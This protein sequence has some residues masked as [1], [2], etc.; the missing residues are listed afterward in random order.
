[1]TKPKDWWVLL[2]AFFFVGLLL[3]GQ[4]LGFDFVRW[5]D[6]LLIY[7]NPAI[8]GITLQNLKTI[9]TTYDPELYIPLTL[10]SYQVDYMLAGTNASMYHATNI[11]LHILNA[12]A[13]VAT[14]CL[15]TKRNGIAILVGIL[16]LVHPIHTEAVVWA[17]AR[18]DLLSTFFFLVSC[19]SFLQYNETGN[20]KWY[21]GSLGI[22]FLG[23]LCK[24]TVLTLPVV[25][26]LMVWKTRGIISLS[27]L[28][29]LIPYCIGSVVFAV[30]A[31]YGK[32][33]VLDLAT[34]IETIAMSGKGTAFYLSKLLAPVRLSVLYPY[35]NSIDFSSP[36]FFVPLGTLLLIGALTLWTLKK[37][38]WT[39]FCMAFFAITLSPSLLNFAKAGTYYVASDRYAY[40]PSIGIL[41]LIVLGIEW[42]LKR[43]QKEQLLTPICIAFAFTLGLGTLLQSQVWANS[44]ALFSNTLRYYPESHVALNNLGN[45]YRRQG[46]LSEA[47]SSYE[48]ALTIDLPLKNSGA[49]TKAQL[50]SN[51]GSAY[52][53]LGKLDLAISTL[54]E[55]L[56]LDAKNPQTYLG[57]GITY[58]QLRNFNE[59]EQSFLTAIELQ[60]TLAVAYLNLG[61]LYVNSGELDKGIAQYENAIKQNPFFPQAHYNLGVAFRKLERNREAKEAFE[62]AVKLQ[63]SFVAARINLGI[64]YAERQDTPEAIQQFQEVLKYDPNN[65]NALSALSQLG[66]L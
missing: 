25:L 6:G 41:L 2:G 56:E 62:K 65:E 18:K 20:K 8:R 24:V 39:V 27:T 60:P 57:L 32:T 17:S 7:E 42:G 54:L 29:K 16:F 37:T 59:A 61:A 23:L 14:I 10:L 50:L 1:M 49:R 38:K 43:I 13:V 9:F 33:A 45:M 40:I 36:D 58:Q 35:N 47:V 3:Y 64:L 21:Y 30:I 11:V 34:P 19:I 51:V 4:T 12:T 5:D 53:A 22:F 44:E 15:L 55:A 26:G 66:A 63:P 46:K 48:T 52:R 28:R 31:F